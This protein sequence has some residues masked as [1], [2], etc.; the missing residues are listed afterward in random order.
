LLAC[1]R[2]DVRTS[3]GTDPLLFDQELRPKLAYWVVRQT[4][5]A[6]REAVG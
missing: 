6:G 4:L 2:C 5:L 1:A 3:A